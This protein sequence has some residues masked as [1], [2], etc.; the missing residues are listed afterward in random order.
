MGQRTRS[1][2]MLSD[3]SLGSPIGE[4]RFLS[5]YQDGRSDSGV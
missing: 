5:V 1:C 3:D 4:E 2:W